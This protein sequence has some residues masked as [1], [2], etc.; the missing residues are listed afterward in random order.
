M[1]MLLAST[2]RAVEF[3]FHLV[4]ED[5][6]RGDDEEGREQQGCGIWSE[7]QPA[8][9]QEYLQIEE[10]VL[11]VNSAQ[12][13]ANHMKFVEQAIYQRR[14]E[15]RRIEQSCIR[16]VPSRL[17]TASWVWPPAAAVVHLQALVS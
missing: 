10:A 4:A 5:D 8:T 9:A 11:S 17:G 16:C 15:E 13:V 3:G 14:E 12:L 2:T 1:H 6:G 7:Y